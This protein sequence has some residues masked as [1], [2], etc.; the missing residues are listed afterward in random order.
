MVHLSHQCPN[1]KQFDLQDRPASFLVHSGGWVVYEKPNYKGRWLYQQ[2]GET[3]SHTPASKGVKLKSWH[4]PVGSIRP[5]VGPDL[6]LLTVK[7][8]MDWSSVSKEVTTSTLLTVEGR[9][10]SFQYVAPEWESVQTFEVSVT[11]R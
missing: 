7:L 1:F 11:H 4:S 2:E 5:I 3:F 8:E 6:Q 10:P 9:N